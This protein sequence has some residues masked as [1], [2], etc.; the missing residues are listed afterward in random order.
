MVLTDLT[1]L[2]LSVLGHDFAGLKGYQGSTPGSIATLIGYWILLTHNCGFISNTSTDT[3]L[4]YVL[5]Q[6]N[7][8]AHVVSSRV[9]AGGSKRVVMI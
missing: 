1:S 8:F 4:W 9:I 7:I 5:L 2:V 3:K 6:F